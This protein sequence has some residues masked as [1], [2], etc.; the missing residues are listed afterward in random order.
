M[1]DIYQILFG[2]F[3]PEA[4]IIFIFL[5]SIVFLVWVLKLIATIL[6]ALPFL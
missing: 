4:Q 3:P 1:I 6:D 2:F 5:F